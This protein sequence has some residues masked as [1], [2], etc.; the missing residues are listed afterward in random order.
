MRELTMGDAKSWLRAIAE[1]PMVTF[2]RDG[3]HIPTYAALDMI[4]AAFE[5]E[6]KRLEELQ[7]HV[8]NTPPPRPQPTEAELRAARV[9]KGKG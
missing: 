8:E 1:C 7:R 4:A 6:A 9:I 3:S 2:S 5:R